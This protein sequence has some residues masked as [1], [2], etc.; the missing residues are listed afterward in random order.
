MVSF[1]PHKWM[2]RVTL[3]K[4]LVQ[5]V[6]LEMWGRKVERRKIEKRQNKAQFLKK[7]YKLILAGII[8]LLC[9]KSF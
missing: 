9:I 4:H 2:N 5:V 3:V 1:F 6:G 7:L 8:S